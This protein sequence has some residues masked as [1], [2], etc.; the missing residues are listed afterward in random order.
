MAGTLASSLTMTKHTLD[1]GVRIVVDSVTHVQSA[2]I[3]LW[4]R[5]GSVHEHD[6]EGGITHL[7]EHMLFKGTEKRTSKEIAEAIEGRGGALNAFTDKESTCYYCRV[8]ADDIENGVDVLSD[9]M[10]NS[11]LDGEE[12]TREEGVVIEEIK[13][14]EDEPESHVHELQIENRWGDHPLGK[15]II[16][17]RDSVASFKPDHLRTYMDRRYRGGNVLLAVAGNVDTEK[18]I[19]WANE[20]LGGIQPGYEEI[21][22]SQPI[23]TAAKDEIAKDVEQV[24]FCMGTDA[25]AVT[26][27]EIYVLRVLDAVLGGGMSSRLFQEIREKRGLAYSV[28]SYSMNYMGGGGFNIY[29]GTGHDTWEQVQELIRTEIDK[30]VNGG[31]VDGELDRAK[32]SISGHIVLALEGMSARMHRIAR[33]EL[34]FGRDI[35]VSESLARIEAVSEQQLR[36]LAAR[37]LTPELISITAIG[38][39]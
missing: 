30:V 36:D 26:D 31:L 13:R 23:G 27:D 39:F 6:D 32:R 14:S 35:A 10:L 21:S 29:G 33:N 1:N 24:H 2:A 34:I 5:T 8:L 11:L 3:G 22:Y 18:V 16:G 19:G 28:G 37:S 9:M 15:P 25:C 12:L 17:T 4:C 7:I 20:R 38:P